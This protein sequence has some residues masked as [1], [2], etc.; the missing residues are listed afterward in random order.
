[1]GWV[2][3]NIPDVHKY[4]QLRIHF[5]TPPN[6]EEAVNK[7]TGKLGP[8]DLV[9]MDG[10]VVLGMSTETLAFGTYNFVPGRR[11][12]IQSRCPTPSVLTVRVPWSW[13]LVPHWRH[14]NPFIPLSADVADPED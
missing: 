12:N 14:T 6:A 5:A 10:S 4:N 8:G 9:D 3:V 11:G 7:I 1:M 13:S 2:V